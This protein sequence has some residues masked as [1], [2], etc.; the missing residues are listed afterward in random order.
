MKEFKRFFYQL[1]PMG[2]FLVIVVAIIILWAAW[3]YVKTLKDTWQGKIEEKS[4]KHALAAQGIKPSYS[5]NQ[6][7]TMAEDLFEAMDGPGTTFPTIQNVFKKMKNDY[8]VLEL[9]AAFGLRS[10]SY[11][12][13][14]LTDPTDL[15]DWLRGDLSE[16]LLKSLNNQLSRQGI[17]KSF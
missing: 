16:D 14:W 13:S 11:S 2:Q 1:P 9:E 15:R 4:E 5:A 17:S 10:S 6:Y 8:D 3:N 12:I 7:V